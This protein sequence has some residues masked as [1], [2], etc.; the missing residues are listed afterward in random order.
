MKLYFISTGF[1]NVPLGLFVQGGGW[2]KV[3]FPILC[4]LVEHDEGLVLFDTGI[5]TRI[6][7]EFKPL[8]YR[9]NWF[10][11]KAVMR[12][13]FEPARDALVNQLPSLGFDPADIRYVVLSH[14]HWD[15]AGGMR[16]L[17]HAHFIANR[18]E[19]EEAVARKGLSLVTGA[20]IKDEFEGAGL[21]VELISTDPARP[22]ISFPA[23]F[24]VFGDGSLV[25]VD[26]P[27]HAP[28]QV[29]MVVNLLSGRRFLLTGDSF[30]FPDSLER[31]A[32]K[33]R[34]MRGLVKEGPEAQDTL[35]RLWR[36]SQDEPDIEMVA[37]HDYRIPGRFELAPAF[38]E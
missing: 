21:D 37:C 34:L 24:D 16:D 7:E 35:D 12:T 32:P 3:R 8:L 2:K 10:F 1:G 26:A 23:S 13:E 5:G 18:R 4:T 17:P 28:G 20:Y 11:S 22:Y 29:G 15:H 19:W 25:L 36:L 9:G 27:G 38:Y 14:L 33:S 31:R 6:E 30:Y